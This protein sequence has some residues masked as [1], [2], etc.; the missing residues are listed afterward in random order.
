MSGKQS[1][2]LWMGLLLIA[3]QFYFGGQFQVL[4]SIIHQPIAGANASPGKKAPKQKATPP[5]TVLPPA[6]GLPGTGPLPGP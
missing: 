4:L 6:P 1:A 2:V 3:A 5:S